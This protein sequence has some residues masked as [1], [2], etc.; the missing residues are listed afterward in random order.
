M[1]IDIISAPEYR[2]LCNVGS[3]LN[4]VRNKSEIPFKNA[5]KICPDL[6]ISAMLTL[7]YIKMSN[8]YG[9]AGDM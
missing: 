9:I 4:R 3:L 1:S 5:W 7:M 2:G 6:I 8:A